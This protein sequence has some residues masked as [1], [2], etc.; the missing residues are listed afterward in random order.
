LITRE[1]EKEK[2]KERQTEKTEMVG[3]TEKHRKSTKR[4]KTQRYT[5]RSKSRKAEKYR[6]KEIEK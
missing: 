5:F 6:D 2:E 4:L 1:R 3:D